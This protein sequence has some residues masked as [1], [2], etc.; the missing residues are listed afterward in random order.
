MSPHLRF[1][2]NESDERT[3]TRI[4]CV[5]NV[6]PEL[7]HALHSSITFGTAVLSSY[8]GNGGLY[9]SSESGLNTSAD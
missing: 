1:S 6:G 5:D 9:F 8:R 2:H 4:W 7:P 3:R